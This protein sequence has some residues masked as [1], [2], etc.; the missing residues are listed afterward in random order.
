MSKAIVLKD[1]KNNKVFL[2]FIIGWTVAG[3]VQNYFTDISGE[4]A[5]YWLFSENPAWGY[6]DHPPV[7]AFIV[8][9]GYRLIPNNLGLRLMILICSILTIIVLRKM[10]AVKDDKLYVWILLGLLPVHAGEMLVKTDV[11]MILFEATFFF[12]YKQYLKKD[13]WKTAVLLALNITLLILSKYHGVL[14]VLFTLLSN[15]RLLRKKSLWA[16]VGLVMLF[17]LPH[18]YWQYLH[19]FASVKFHLYNRDDLGFEWANIYGYLVM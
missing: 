12:L 5:Y 3:L 11:P 18:L 7:I 8:K 19:D 17:M 1:Q 13:N 6:L 4:E 14:V 16:I 2:Y 15:I 9:L 10:L